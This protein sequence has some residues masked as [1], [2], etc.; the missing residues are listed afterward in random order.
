MITVLIVI[1]TLGVTSFIVGASRMIYETITGNYTKDNSWILWAYSC[2]ALIALTSF[3]GIACIHSDQP[4]S[5]R[6]SINK[7][8]QEIEVLQ[9]ELKYK[10]NK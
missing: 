1:C 8:Q 5:I 6:D 9:I 2:G 4:D 3:V 7:K 10:E